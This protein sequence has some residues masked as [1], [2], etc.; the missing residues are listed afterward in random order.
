MGRSGISRMAKKLQLP[1]HF[2]YF[3]PLPQ[4]QGSFL[5]TFGWPFFFWSSSGLMAFTNFG[6][7][8]SMYGYILLPLNDGLNSSIRESKSFSRL[9]SGLSNIFRMINSAFCGYLKRS[10]LK[11]WGDIVW[12]SRYV[13]ISLLYRGIFNSSGL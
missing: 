5:P 10:L 9:N 13:K 11:T 12:S 8:G 2:L 1:Q 3:F 6:D 4:G 7:M